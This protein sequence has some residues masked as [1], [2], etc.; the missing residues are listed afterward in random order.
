MIGS[1]PGSAIFSPGEPAEAIALTKSARRFKGLS[2]MRL[3]GTTEALSHAQGSI[4]LGK[5][6]V[7]KTPGE[8]L[9]IAC[10]AATFA[11]QDA[12]SL[13]KQFGIEA[14]ILHLH[15]V[16]PLDVDLVR[17]CAKDAKVIL[18]VEEH[19]QIGG[20]SSA[21]LHALTSAEPPIQPARFASI[22][23]DDTFPFG[24]GAYEDHMNHYG[25]TGMKLAERARELLSHAGADLPRHQTPLRAAQEA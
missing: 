3:A 14:G 16:K 18:C 17:R 7:F 5:G 6:R 21:V 24:Y 2:Y 19:R 1:I 10:G 25:I 8:V 9:F 4:D 23:V 22:G 11:V 13:L 12:V 20:L 15:T